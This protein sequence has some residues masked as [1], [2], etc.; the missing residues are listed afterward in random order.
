MA[1]AGIECEMIYGSC[2]SHLFAI[3]YG[4]VFGMFNVRN[5]CE[6]SDDPS[7]INHNTSGNVAVMHKNSYNL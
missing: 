4:M 3:N 2:A 1:V 5:S 6:V 7:D